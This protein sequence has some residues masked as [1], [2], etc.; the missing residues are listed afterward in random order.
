M[1][2]YKLYK[3]FRQ[4]TLLFENSGFRILSICSQP[5]RTVCSYKTYCGCP[6]YMK[7]IKVT[8]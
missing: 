3:A 7:L 2:I 1:F 8:E 4:D 6:A 5:M